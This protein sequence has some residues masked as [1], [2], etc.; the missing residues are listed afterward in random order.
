MKYIKTPNGLTFLSKHPLWAVNAA[1]TTQQRAHIIS[2]S[3][4]PEK[5]D[6]SAE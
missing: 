1:Y 3:R 5:R 4:K 6:T 2:I